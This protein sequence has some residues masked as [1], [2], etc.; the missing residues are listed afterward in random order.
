MDKKKII[1]PSI[2]AYPTLRA[3]EELDLSCLRVKAE[4]ILDESLVTTWTN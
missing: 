1:H 2:A 3:A 4:D